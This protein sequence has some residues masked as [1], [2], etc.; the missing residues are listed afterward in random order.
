MQPQ[1][2]FDFCHFKVS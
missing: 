1:P 2:L